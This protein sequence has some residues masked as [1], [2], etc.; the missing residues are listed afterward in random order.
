[1]S[2]KK[3]EVIRQEI[4]TYKCPVCGK[5]WS[6]EAQATACFKAHVVLE[7]TEP[8]QIRPQDIKSVDEFLQYLAA[9]FGVPEKK[10]ISASASYTQ[11][12]SSDAHIICALAPPF[13]IQIYDSQ[14]GLTKTVTLEHVDESL[15][16]PYKSACPW[17]KGLEKVQKYGWYSSDYTL[18]IKIDLSYFPAWNQAYQELAEYKK[19]AVDWGYAVKEWVRLRT[20]APHS[21]IAENQEIIEQQ[22]ALK[23]L[24]AEQTAL[25]RRR[26]RVQSKIGELKARAC[27]QAYEEYDAN[28]PRPFAREQQRI[29]ELQKALRCIRIQVKKLFGSDL[30]APN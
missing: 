9:G 16:G 1:M 11:A 25:T 24:D 3:I 30:T 26:Q 28:N 13:S 4:V 27:I 8:G 12:K 5:S 10:W 22:E 18:R 17:Y 2:S 20:L 19:P 23:K 7:W 14:E 21:K 6:K 29:V 15:R